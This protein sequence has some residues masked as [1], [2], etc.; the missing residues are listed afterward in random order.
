MEW[1]FFSLL[2]QRSKFVMYHIN[3]DIFVVVE[4]LISYFHFF[5]DI[6]S[7]FDCSHLQSNLAPIFY[8]SV[9]RAR[10]KFRHPLAFLVMVKSLLYHNNI[11]YSCRVTGKENPKI[12]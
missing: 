5:L 9:I 4:C 11:R 7:N 1:T 12:T 10:L 3:L 2:Y 6:L 8:A